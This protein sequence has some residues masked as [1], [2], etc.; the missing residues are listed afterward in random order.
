MT[1]FHSLILGIIE[2]LTEFLPISSTA[3]LILAAKL[4]ELDQT[5]FLKTFEIAI[6]SG[7]ILAVIFIFWRRLVNK[8]ILK[9]IIVAFIP[10]A[11]VGLLLYKLIKNYLFE[12]VNV[13]LISLA[14]GGFILIIFERFIKQSSEEKHEEYETA[15]SVVKAHLIKRECVT[16]ANKLCLI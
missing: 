9:R 10:T 15:I 2:G 4:L 5:P 8:E 11:I 16:F 3:H 13:I 1:A 6:Q 12:N 14:V 7:A